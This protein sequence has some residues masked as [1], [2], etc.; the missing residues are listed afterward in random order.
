MST[1]IA[2]RVEAIRKY[3]A[4]NNLDAF[5]LPTADPHLGEYQPENAHRVTWLSGFHGENCMVVITKDT[6]GIF[7][8][9]RFT[10]QVKQQVPADIFQYLHINNDCHLNWTMDNLS[11]G[12][13]IAVDASLFGISWYKNAEK[14]FTGK[15]FEIVS[16]QEN[17]VD[18]FWEDRPAAPS[19]AIELF[20]NAGQSSVEKRH[21]LAKRLQEKELDA[22]LLTQPEDT[23]W[24]VNIRGS[25]IPYVRSVLS[26]GLFKNNGE[27]ELFIDTAR[28]PEG[29]ADHAGEGVN[30]YDITA[31]FSVL[32]EKISADQRIQLDPAQTNAGL[33]NLLHDAG[34]SVVEDMN[35]CARARVCK[36]EKEIEG[37]KAAHIQDGIAMCRFL[38]W[39]DREVEAGNPNDEETLA[40]KLLEFR[41]GV[42]GFIAP[43]FPSISALGSN[44]AIVHYNH[45]PKNCRKLGSDG[46]YLIDSG[47]HYNN[48]NGVSGTTDITRTIKVGNATDEERRMVTLVMRSHISLASARFMPGT[49][50]V[51]LDTVTRQ[52]MWKEGFNFDHGTG[53]GIG[54]FLSVH[55]FPPRINPSNN[56]GAME[57]GMCV[58]NEPGFYKED[59]FGIRLEN[60][61]VVR[62]VTGTAASML[63]LEAITYTPFD[64]RLL[65]AEQMRDDEIEWLNNYHAQVFEKI[66][67]SLNKQD[68]TWLEQATSPLTRG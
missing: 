57:P 30:V 47:G 17:P 58:T 60:V 9:G 14:A 64:K 1:T 62:E 32:P 8:D 48:A 21:L 2:Q 41:Q 54:H 46:M 50:G 22:T 63:E 28:L 68:K 67:P 33:F 51:Q 38:A 6:A 16:L 61:E 18:L 5:L 26:F 34:V 37:M 49:T 31:L 12:A 66:A 40:A 43:S 45:D 4:D 15:G 25:D 20:Q 59:G 23:N 11:A 44:A 52:P 55:E 42:E 39:V 3:L 7:V 35:L 27:L 29:F 19:S 10:V 65:V 24:L 13:R 53:H 36:N 56:C